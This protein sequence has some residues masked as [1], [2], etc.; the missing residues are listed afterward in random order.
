MEKIIKLG[1]FNIG[2]SKYIAFYNSVIDGIDYYRLSEEDND[3]ECWTVKRASLQK[4][5]GSKKDDKWF[6]QNYTLVLGFIFSRELD[7]S[8]ISL[9]TFERKFWDDVVMKDFVNMKLTTLDKEDAENI[10]Q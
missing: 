1:W 2:E 3:V 4:I 6:K 8:I 7:E 9:Q 5:V 10:G